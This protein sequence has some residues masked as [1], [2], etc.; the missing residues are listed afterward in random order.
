M[1]SDDTLRGC[2]LCPCNDTLQD[3]GGCLCFDT[4]CFLFSD[5]L[6]S[7]LYVFLGRFSHKPEHRQGDRSAAGM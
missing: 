2:R 5:T 4:L 3:L 6:L 1:T 7:S